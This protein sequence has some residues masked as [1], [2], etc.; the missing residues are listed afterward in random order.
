MLEARVV[1]LKYGGRPALQDVSL[2]LGEGKVVVMVG[3]NGA[4]KT[5]L[6]R[7]LNGTVPISGGTIKLDGMDLNARSRREIACRISVVAQE[8]ET[9]FPISVLEFV[10]SGRFAHGGAFGWET[11]DDVTAARAALVECDLQ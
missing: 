1:T 9:R 11:E 3:A 4:G 8:N 7:A 10:I 5:T 2:F 6:I